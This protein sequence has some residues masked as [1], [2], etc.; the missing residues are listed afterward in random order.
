MNEINA[1]QRLRS[2]LPGCSTAV[3]W[4]PLEH[5]LQLLAS[6]GP[7]RCPSAC[8][9]QGGPP[10]ARHPALPA[11]TVGSLCRVAALEKAEAEKVQVVKAAEADS[12]AKYL[13]GQARPSWMWGVAV[14][15]LSGTCSAPTRRACCRAYN[16]AR[17]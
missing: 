14:G 3:S 7:C 10:R 4:E 9:G 17:G 13:Q 8:C 1:A 2:R 11:P 12:E 6:L 5:A 16:G 15:A